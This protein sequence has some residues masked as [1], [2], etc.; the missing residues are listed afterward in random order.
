MLFDSHNHLQ[1]AKFG[2]P[3]AELIAGMRAAG[4]SGCVA[5]ATREADWEAVAALAREFSGFVFPAYGIHPWFADTAE[6]GWGER[7]RERLLADPAASVGEAGVDGW[8]D[9]PRMEVQ[10]PVFVKQAEIAAELGRAMTV[11]CLK[12]WEPLF[13]AMDRAA[14]WPEKFLMH[15]FGGSAEVAERLL[16]KGAWFSFSGHFLHPRKAKV[17]EVFRKLPAD[18]ILLETDAPDMIPPEEC[19]AFPL[20]DGVNHP[21][22]FGKIAEA[23]AAGMGADILARVRE[24]GRSFWN[25]PQL[26]PLIRDL[27][28]RRRAN[29]LY[30]IT[31]ETPIRAV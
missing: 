31:N 30:V 6:E 21:A 4:I 5:N 3:A 18:R 27:G 14:A 11:H 13:E 26:D 25:Q 24:N 12:A 2:K 20:A 23:F 16:K 17:L 28:L 8:V 9:S 10:I 29:S 22:N 7:L 1:S 15:S 19:I